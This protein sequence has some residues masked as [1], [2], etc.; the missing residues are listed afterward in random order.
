MRQNTENSRRS[1]EV[2]SR[3]NGTWVPS[4]A[5]EGGEKQPVQ[6]KKVS[7]TYSS[8]IARLSPIY[9][10]RYDLPDAILQRYLISFLWTSAEH[11]MHLLA[12]RPTVCLQV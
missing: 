4:S 9:N 3:R 6:E 7:R 5:E 10:L 8:R 1:T 11:H 2:L 12:D